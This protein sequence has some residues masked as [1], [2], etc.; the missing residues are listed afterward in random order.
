MKEILVIAK[1]LQKRLLCQKS[2]WI[3][4][5][6]IPLF[7]IVML[8]LENSTET[9]VYVA[10]YAEDKEVW[11]DFF[12]KND[13]FV[14]FYFV[15]TEEELKRDVLT[16]K[17]ECG[18][19]LTE[20]LQNKF[21]E[22]DWYWGIDVYESSQSMLT[23]TINETVFSRVFY[24]ISSKWYEGYIAKKASINGWE[25]GELQDTVIKVLEQKM[26]DGSTF[27]IETEYILP[28]GERVDTKASV[29]PV[30]GIVGM[31]VY[32]CALIGVMQ[33]LYDNRK[34]YFIRKRPGIARFLTIGSI[35]FYAG[36]VGYITLL[37]TGRSRGIWQEF[38]D[39]IFYVLLVTFYGMVLQWIVREEKIMA[40]LIPFLILGSLI[41]AP[42]FF[43][44]GSMLPVL[45]I[46]KKIFPITYY[47]EGNL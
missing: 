41:C 25:L 37:V 28:M 6:M 27:S 7:S 13:G 10:I 47:L 2:F 14:R 21:D 20:D 42:I 43:D 44:L 38:I 1:I 35:T 26:S 23:K 30:R 19:I 40:G 32:L 29:F 39:I 15:S 18:Y 46:F 12:Y 34:Q 36:A 9:A 31:G 45:D 16:R 33:V 22:D 11:E 5:I 8:G 17:A 3:C 4:M 24:A